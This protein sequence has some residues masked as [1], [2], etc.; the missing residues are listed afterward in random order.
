MKTRRSRDGSCVGN[1]SD[2]SAVCKLCR[3]RDICINT[4]LGRNCYTINPRNYCGT[5]SLDT[6][7][8]IIL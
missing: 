1:Y 8:G 7:K 4:F 5:I 2:K 6:V 3:V